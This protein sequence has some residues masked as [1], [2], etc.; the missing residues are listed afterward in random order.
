MNDE[1]PLSTAETF[2]IRLQDSL[3]PFADH[4]RRY[5]MFKNRTN[6][7]RDEREGPNEPRPEKRERERRDAPRRSSEGE[8]RVLVVKSRPRIPMTH[9]KLEPRGR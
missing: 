7:R 8:P 3:G 2:L 4:I 9:G 6:Y 5:Y 1:F